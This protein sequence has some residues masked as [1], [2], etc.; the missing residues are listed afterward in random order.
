MNEGRFYITTPIYYVN[1][2][3]H[4]GHAYTTCA[5]DILARFHR[6]L[7]EQVFFL[8]GTDEHGDKIIKAAREVGIPPRQLVD[9]VVRRFQELWASM[10]ISHDDFVRTTEERHVQTVQTLFR[11]LQENGYIYKGEYEGW[12][13]IPCE[14]FWPENQLD[15]RLRCPDCGRSLERLKEE[16]YF[17]ALSHFE[18]KLLAHFEKTPRLVMPESRYN[19]IV[20][21]IRSGLKDQ[22]ISRTGMD[23][24]VPVPGD[25]THTLYVWFDALI[26]YVT[27]TGFLDDRERFEAFWPV[28]HHLVGKDILRFHAT[29]WP[30][31]L[32]GAEI[33]L[34]KRVFA[35]G[36][37]T[38]EGEKMSKSRGNV[39][40]P[41][42]M[43]DRYGVDRF[44]YFI[45]REVTFGLD[46]D[47]SERAL[48]E[49]CNADLSDNFGNMVHRS[50]SMLWKYREGRV[51]RP[52]NYRDGEWEDLLTDVR[53]N[54]F[55]FMDVFAFAQVLEQ[56]WKLAHFGNRYI[57]RRTPWLLYKDPSRARELD[58]ILYRLC[59][60]S[61]LLALLVYPFLPR[62]AQ[63]LWD[64][65]GLPGRLAECRIIEE[66]SWERGP[67]AY[68]PASPQ[69][70]FPR[71]IEE[72]KEEGEVRRETG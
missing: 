20:S 26:N 58:E 10:D 17:F 6:L 31:M 50:L 13:C 40:D 44:R 61:R 36:W 30:A 38:V 48:Q 16:S 11:I 54:I 47:F 56:I 24:G 1:D 57:D 67:A 14:T 63:K 29:L 28:A 64:M 71:L 43:I 15:E 37:W 33:A 42:L 2:V 45:M 39:V 69:P 68:T 49:R 3:P 66:L 9:R 12:Y 53:G 65:L 51:S 23:W 4:I 34:P 27:A 21:F 25:P 72:E 52:I 35:H 62:S 5:A 46:G 41:W 8:T 18:Q 60:A 70:L 19:E 22:S 32:M 7:G 55:R 59:D